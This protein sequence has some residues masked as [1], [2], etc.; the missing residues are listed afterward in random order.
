MNITTAKKR[1]FLAA[2]AQGATVLKATKAAKTSRQCAY[3]WRDNDPAF[4][5]SW[6]EAKQ[7]GIDVLEDEVHRRAVDGILEDVYH[8][9]VI[10]G[11]RVKYSD[12]LLIFALNA[13]NPAKYRPKTEVHHSGSIDFTATLHA[14]HQKALTN[15]D[16]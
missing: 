11:Q 4:A 12:T 15:G 3:V 16:L 13:A 1:K 7:C 5:A 10:I 6:A 2:I 14:A 9:G 8:N